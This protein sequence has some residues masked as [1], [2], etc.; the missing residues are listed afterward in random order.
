MGRDV[1]EADI[2]IKQEMLEPPSP[3]PSPPE[4]AEEEVVVLPGSIPTPRVPWQ[5]LH[6][7]V[8]DDNVKTELRFSHQNQ[9]FGVR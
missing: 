2:G 1:E 9:V 6:T 8:L 3:P 7:T 4:E 5:T